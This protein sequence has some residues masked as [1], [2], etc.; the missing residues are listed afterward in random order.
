MV[1]GGVG[2]RGDEELGPGGSGGQDDRDD[3]ETPGEPAHG[4]GPIIQGPASAVPGTGR[5]ARDGLISPGPL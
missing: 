1:K 5:R 4:R 2:A 3:G